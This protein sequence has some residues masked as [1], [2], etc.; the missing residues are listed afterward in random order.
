MS[1]RSLLD[2]APAFAVKRSERRVRVHHVGDE[3][4]MRG[5]G[6]E[7]RQG[8]GPVGQI[9]RARERRHNALR[10]HGRFLT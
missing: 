10:D 6:D 8:V 3:A 1:A 5:H 7:V 4:P 9:V 2:G